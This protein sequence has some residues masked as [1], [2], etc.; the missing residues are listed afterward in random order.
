[1]ASLK[2]IAASMGTGALVASGIWIL[3]LAGECKAWRGAAKVEKRPI[4]VSQTERFKDYPTVKVP[5]D[6]EIP[7]IP[8]KDRSKLA[9]KY[10]RP[11][12]VP[13]DAFKGDLSPD[14]GL[15]GATP[16]ILGEFALPRLPEGGDALVTAG[17]DGRVRVDVAPRPKPFFGFEPEWRIR[18]G[19]GVDSAG[20]TVGGVLVGWTAPRTGRIKYGVD[21]LLL[22]GGGGSDTRLVGLVTIGF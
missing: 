9:D 13:P 19:V 4:H 1:M 21:G 12:L 14:L 17:P 11:D 10:G 22:L 16:S 6:L 18:A 7:V 15:G 20:Q 8:Y 2:S 5:L 3:V